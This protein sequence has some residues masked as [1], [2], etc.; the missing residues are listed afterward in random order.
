MSAVCK[1]DK[2]SCD[3]ESLV[4]RFNPSDVKPFYYEIT[5]GSKR[6]FYNKGCSN[7]KK[8]V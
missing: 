3:G 5:D 8:V 6:L 1:I 4:C 7:F 2:K